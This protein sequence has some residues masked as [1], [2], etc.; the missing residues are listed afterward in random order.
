MNSLGG[1]LSEAD[2]IRVLHVDDDPDLLDLS[3]AFLEREDERFEWETETNPDKAIDRLGTGEI[4]CIVS[5]YDMPQ[6][7]GLSFLRAVRDGYPGFPFILF[8]GKGSEEIASEA[9][10]A[11]V[12]DYLQKGRGRDQYAVLANRVKNAVG[13]YRAQREV[14]E[15]QDRF[16]KLV[17]HSTDVISIVDA[18]GRWEYMTPSAERVLGYTPE[19][20]IG[21][22]GFEYTHPDDREK[23]MAT[24]ATAVESPELIPETEFRFAHSSGEWIWT[25]NYARNML[26]DPLINGFIVH[27]REITDRKEDELELE[28]QNNRLDEFAEIVSHDLRNPLLVTR[29]YLAMVKEECDSEHIPVMERNLDRMERI[30]DRSLT[31][32]KSGRSI[33]EYE[34]IDLGDVIETCC[35]HLQTGSVEVVLETDVRLEANADQL[36]ILVENLLKN[37][38]NHGGSDVQVRFGIL[39]GGFYVEDDGPGFADDPE[40]MFESGYSTVEDGIGLGLTICQHIADAHDWDLQAMEAESGGARFEITGVEFADA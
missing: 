28:R 18:S 37:A 27:T 13:Q 20:L 38:I 36:E 9:I 17:E 11:G 8:T 31:L 5:D 34:S 35:S 3:G 12:T 19:E 16:Q 15:T 30:V 21:E 23:T 39:P 4:D 24:F 10:Q 25:H 22:I 1:D 6:M 14:T 7:D 26:D 29:G 2:R 33:L 40:T 32:V